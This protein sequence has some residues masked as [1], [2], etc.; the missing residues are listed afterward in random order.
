[1]RK[2]YLVCSFCVL[3][4]AVVASWLPTAE[5]HFT[6]D[7]SSEAVASNDADDSDGVQ[8]AAKGSDQKAKASKQL[9]VRDQPLSP[10]ESAGMLK[11]DPGFHIQLIATEPQVVSPIDAAFDDRGRLWV[12]E[13]ID[14]PFPPPNQTEPRGRIRILSDND[15]DGRYEKATVFA[16]KLDMPTGLGLWKDGAVVTLGG[17]LEW[18]RDTDQDGQVD[19]REVWLEG[20]AQQ[21]E[22]LRANHPRLEMDGRWY[23]ASGLRG[24]KIQ[25]GEALRGQAAAESFELGTRDV[26]LDPRTGRAEAITG[27]AQFGLTTDITGS[28]M[29]CPNR[30]PCVQVV[31]EQAMLTDN[32]LAGIVPAVHDALPAGEASRV[33]PLVE[34]WTTSNLHAGQFTAACGVHFQ[35]MPATSSMPDEMIKRVHRDTLG[36]VYACEPT[37]SLVHSQSVTHAGSLWSVDQTHQ[38]TE[39]PSEWLA[40]RDPWF[41]PV[42]VVMAP[43]GG[44]LVIDMHRAVIEHPAWVPDE[45]KNRPDERFGEQAGRIY[46]AAQND[47][48]WPAKI[49]E[50]LSAR[51][52]SERDSSE[53]VALLTSDDIW[54]RRTAA[55]LLIERDAVDT[56]PEL[57]KLVAVGGDRSPETQV[58]AWQLISLFDPDARSHLKAQLTDTH[59]LVQITALRMLS[60]LPVSAEGSDPTAATSTR[61][62]LELAMA[63]ADSWLRLEATI[64]AART[65][66][67]LPEAEAISAAEG[68]GRLAAMYADDAQ[69]LVA[70]AGTA[71]K[72]TAPFLLSW[73]DGLGQIKSTEPTAQ[74]GRDAL[75]DKWL[76]AAARQLVVHI[77]KHEPAAMID[78]VARVRYLLTTAENASP[79]SQLA[80]LSA[81]GQYARTLVA[82]HRQA[83]KGKPADAEPTDALQAIDRPLWRKIREIARLT[84]T[85]PA[86]RLAAVELLGLSQR[87]GDKTL[88]TELATQTEDGTLR[89]AAIKA[90]CEQ[91]SPEAEA[92]LLSQIGSAGPALR[93]TILEQLLAR[94]QRQAALLTSMKAG[95]LTA[96]QLGAVELKR[97]VD[98]SQGDVKA[99]FQQ[100]LDSILNSDRAAVLKSYQSCLELAGDMTRGKQ[101]FVKQ[102]AACHRIGDVGVQVG[103]D[104]SDSRV[105]TPDKILTSVLDPNRAIDNNYFRF[106]VLTSDG[107]TIDGLIAEETS[108]KLVIRSQN[109]QRHV[110]ARADIE[111][112][113]PTG[114]SMMPE[115]LESQIDPQSMADL[116]AFIK[117]WRYSGGQIPAGIRAGK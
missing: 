76:T 72:H 94:P 57:L 113:K 4:V 30:N 3:S 52:L 66:D 68:L 114:V 91:G 48:L 115:G 32:P 64:C 92:Y 23:I 53:L 84:E 75:R 28:R 107:R 44:V 9:G 97:F 88:L 8:D 49:M 79:V 47:K 69:L 1:M 70:G 20:F 2:V 45:L 14:Y 110:I 105:Q 6:N 82:E 31:F 12:V 46:W 101:V 41:R 29:F 58:I 67:A 63:T 54:L 60:R 99:G 22:Q 34:A 104:I 35:H 21:N 111:Q 80:A 17:K 96:K 95:A 36:R 42:N 56:V 15:R 108:D 106:V 117:N 10:A 83:I 55:R 86:V 71:R 74:V 18:M 24:G 27:P 90:W 16:D 11:I 103:P 51:P 62:A 116:I 37:G 40:S 61:T 78:L 38:A 77:H 25:V 13:M 112:L 89:T 19:K 73:L 26:R 93:P 98:R 109:D 81:M 39:P 5:S 65:I 33:F 59:R 87:K 102:C 85:A 43:A 100:Q 7:R 50:G